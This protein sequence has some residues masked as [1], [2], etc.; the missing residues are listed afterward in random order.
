MTF[1]WGEAT[2][3]GR[4][5]GE[6]WGF[7]IPTGQLTPGS[8]A[9]KSFWASPLVSSSA[10][11]GCLYLSRLQESF[12]ETCVKMCVPPPEPGNAGR[13]SLSLRYSKPLFS[14]QPY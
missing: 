9:P 14:I 6:S 10:N 3:R 8:T 11:Q 1:N 5:P 7:R 2:G 13:A 12:S 4:E